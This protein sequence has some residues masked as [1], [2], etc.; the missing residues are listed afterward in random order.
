MDTITRRDL[1]TFGLLAGFSTFQL[2][3]FLESVDNHG[4]LFSEEVESVVVMVVGGAGVFI[5]SSTK[6]DVWIVSASSWK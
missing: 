5:L 1:F 3:I 2:Q 4:K 6:I